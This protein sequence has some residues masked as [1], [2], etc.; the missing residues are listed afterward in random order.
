[1]ANKSFAIYN[2]ENLPVHIKEKP[3]GEMKFLVTKDG[4]MFQTQSYQGD[5]MILMG[6]YGTPETDIVD[7]LELFRNLK[8][9]KC[10]ISFH[11]EAE[12]FIAHSSFVE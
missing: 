9:G 3:I 12:E 7:S 5:E 4:K 6:I 1:M 10:A 8:T 11:S 2:I